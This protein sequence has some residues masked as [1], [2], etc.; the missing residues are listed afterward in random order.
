MQPLT[1]AKLISVQPTATAIA[2]GGKLQTL[3]FLHLHAEV[4]LELNFDL[5]RHTWRSYQ[6]QPLEMAPTLYAV[7]Y[8]F[9]TALT[10]SHDH[11]TALAANHQP[12]QQCKGHS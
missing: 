5:V 11:I 12:Y 6:H 7:V 1:A 8:S 2:L 9:L 4:A 10:S 3:R